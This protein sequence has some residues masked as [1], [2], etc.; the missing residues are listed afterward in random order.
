MKNINVAQEN[1]IEKLIDRGNFVLKEIDALY[2]LKK[3]RAL[4]RNYYDE[5]NITQKIDEILKKV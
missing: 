4:K 5:D 1:E 3:Y 2:K